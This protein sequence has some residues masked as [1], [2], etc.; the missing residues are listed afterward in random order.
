VEMEC[1]KVTKDALFT[2]SGIFETRSLT[3]RSLD[4]GARLEDALKARILGVAIRVLV[5]F[6]RPRPKRN[7]SVNHLGPK[8]HCRL[9]V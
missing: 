5:L 3:P 1:Q 2:E 9:R 4:T 6:C 8:R 7:G